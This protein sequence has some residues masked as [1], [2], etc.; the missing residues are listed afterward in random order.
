MRSAF[1]WK[2]LRIDCT[3]QPSWGRHHI[4]F[5]FLS[6]LSFYALCEKICDKRTYLND[7]RGT[8]IRGNIFCTSF[9]CYLNVSNIDIRAVMAFES[10][11]DGLA[12]NHESSSIL[13][14]VFFD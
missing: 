2:E 8:Q 9:W 3:L 13:G 5:V 1:G 11:N 4:T 14:K 6:L 7:R 10:F 12:S